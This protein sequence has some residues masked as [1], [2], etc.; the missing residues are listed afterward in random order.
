MRRREVEAGP[1]RPGLVRTFNV[2]GLRGAGRLRIRDVGGRALAEVAGARET[3]DATIGFL[4]ERL[5][6]R[7][8]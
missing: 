6:M 8:A 3:V 7:G 1:E 2:V 4:A 5:G